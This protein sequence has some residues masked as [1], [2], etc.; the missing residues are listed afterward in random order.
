MII[1]YGGSFNPPT[2]A[3]FE[4]AKYLISKYKPLKFVFVPVGSYYNKPNVANF[5]DR[6]NML[7]IIAKKL[8]HS[9]VTD[10]EDTMRPFKGTISTLDYYKSQNPSQE[11][12]FV[13]GA[14]NL[15]TLDQWIR[16]EE[17]LKKYYF[18]ILNRNQIDVKNLIHTNYLL[19]NY[20]NKFIIEENLP[21]INI[22]A[23]M[24]RNSICDD[25]VLKEINDYIYSHKLFNRGVL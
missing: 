10:F 21:N 14:D 20:Q 25:V 9:I 16:I 12:Y 1:L 5:N 6:K 18:I 7:E 24:Y 17:M 2:I 3:H 23:T 11:L 8:D 13:L 19:K 4:I 22:S 15:M